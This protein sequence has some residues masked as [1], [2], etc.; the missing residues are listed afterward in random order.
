MIRVDLGA[1]AVARTRFAVSPVH[2]LGQ[3]LF[4]LGHRPEQL[5]REL[6]RSVADAVRSQGLGLVARLLLGN[7]GGY[8]PDFLSPRPLDFACDLDGELHR[9]TCTAPGRVAYEMR[10]FTEC[11]ALSGCG[12]RERSALVL[13]ALD[14]GEQA[15]A[16]TVAGQLERLWQG[17][18]R[19]LWP[20]LRDRMESDIGRRA[21]SAARSGFAAM[22]DLLAPSLGWR[23]G[24]VDI[25]LGR[26][27]RSPDHAEL[28]GRAAA[29]FAILT[30]S[31]FSRTAMY[32]LDTDGAP[33]KQPLTVVYPLPP[34]EEAGRAGLGELIGE[35]RGRVLAEL[36][37]PRTTAELAGRLYLSPATVSYHLGILHRSGLLSRTRRARQVYYQR[38]VIRSVP[39][40]TSNGT[41]RA[42]AAP[43]STA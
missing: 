22:A 11:A 19:P 34:A 1:D 36:A 30:P 18:L 14:R 9:I 35:T 12:R 31:A 13:N 7:R 8:T 29:D 20:E 21:D 3:L 25:D 15:L 26:G 28:S 23:D 33:D 24:G 10:A 38:A 4:L 40:T 5:G 32:C 41:S 2:S 42:N 16:A 27:C 37:D 39:Y 6:R 43:A 17:T